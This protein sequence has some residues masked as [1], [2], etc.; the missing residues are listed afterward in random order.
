MLP[1][2][3]DLLAQFVRLGGAQRIPQRR[4]DSPLLE[5]DVSPA[6]RRE[7]LHQIVKLGV[8]A[9]GLIQPLQ[10]LLC[11]R[12][13]ADPAVC[14]LVP[15]GEPAPDDRPEVMLLCSFV[16]RRVDHEMHDGRA[17]GYHDLFSGASGDA[18]AGL[19]SIEQL[20]S[21]RVV[22]TKDLENVCHRVLPA[23]CRYLGLVT[24][25]GSAKRCQNDRMRKTIA[26]FGA[27]C[28]SLLVTAV[29]PAAAHG[30]VSRRPTP[31]AYV[32]IPGAGSGDT[33]VPINTATNKAGA[34]ITVGKG[35]RDIAITPGGRTAYVADV[36]R[37]KANSVI[38]TGRT[39]TPVNLATA[40]AGQPI[41]VGKD[42]VQ[43]LITPDG[44]TA[45]VADYY[46]RTVTPINTATDTA[47]PR[48]YVGNYPMQMAITPNGKTIYVARNNG[49]AV[50]PI[51]T[52]TNT[53]GPPIRVAGDAQDIAVTPNGATAYVADGNT[54]H[55][56]PINTATNT[57]EPTIKVGGFV[58][59]I[60][61]SPNGKTAYALDETGGAVVP[62]NTATNKVGKPIKVGAA[63][64]RIAISANGKTLYVAGFPAAGIY[65]IST[66]TG[67]VGKPIKVRG[68]YPVDLAISGSTLY[69]VTESAAGFVTPISTATNKAGKAIRLSGDP[70]GIAF[71]P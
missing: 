43:V 38:P 68:Q 4:P 26:V 3:R 29:L 59:A 19:E 11:V 16:T 23:K 27:L 60:A 61:I 53:A 31:T 70:G 30:A 18:R 63:V 49:K 33:V 8:S 37:I 7:R 2:P 34:P 10:H 25:A 66:A 48:I 21:G 56:T 45:Y 9:A 6:L 35:P 64:F 51:N 24:R 17:T 50:T 22:R 58:G 67:K 40:K 62:I 32:S 39:V 28:A 20:L 1:G 42:P 46:S 71:S 54:T 36:G 47:E 14:E 55:V 13:L 12:F 69:A 41:R 57:A 15:V 44:K 5:L 52:A 65:P